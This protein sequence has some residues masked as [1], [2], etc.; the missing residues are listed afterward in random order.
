MKVMSVGE[1]KT[2]FS[3]V[4]KRVQAGEEIDIAYGKGKE[5]VA[6]LI[7]KPSTKKRK[8]KLGVLDA[9]GKIKFNVGFRMTEQEFL[10][11]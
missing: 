2:K 1:F 3:E 5:I 11:A 6:R 4:L 7:P 8:R 10:E 9:N